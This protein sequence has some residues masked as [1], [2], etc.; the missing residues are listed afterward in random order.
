MCLFRWKSKHI[1]ILRIY[2]IFKNYK[3][4]KVNMNY[5]SYQSL[6]NLININYIIPKTKKKIKNFLIYF[7]SL[8]R[9]WNRSMIWY[10]IEGVKPLHIIFHK[11]NRFIG[12][13]EN[14]HLK[15]LTDSKKNVYMV[16]KY[17]KIWNKII[18]LI[19]LKNDNVNSSNNILMEIKRKI[20]DDLPTSKN[21][22]KLYDA[23]TFI[24]SGF[25][26]NDT[27]HQYF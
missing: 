6:D 5:H 24:R 2:K 21:Y 8:H 27:F 9:I 3:L 14:N 17:Q 13:D 26:N 1:S 18:Y 4:E 16:E 25:E 22:K 20:D 12:D 23:V 15:L 10:D 7:C 19:G 11:V